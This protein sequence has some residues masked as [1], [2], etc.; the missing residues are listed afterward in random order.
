MR[1]VINS[2]IAAALAAVAEA[3]IDKYISGIPQ[4]PAPPPPA[5]KPTPR[6]RVRVKVNSSPKGKS[7]VT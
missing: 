7:L 5:L 6:K 1:L 4:T 2:A 3:L